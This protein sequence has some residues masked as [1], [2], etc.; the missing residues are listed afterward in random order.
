MGV[1]GWRSRSFGDCIRLSM[2]C[3][4]EKPKVGPGKDQGKQMWENRDKGTKRVSN[5]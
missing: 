5:L 1:V 4:M 2:G 3:L